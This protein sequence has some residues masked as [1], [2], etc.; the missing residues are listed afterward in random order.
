M[1]A[2]LTKALQI[3]ALDNGMS[4]KPLH[5]WEWPDNA[6]DLE[7]IAQVLT[8]GELETLVAGEEIEQRAI[9]VENNADALHGFLNNAFDGPLTD[10][11]FEET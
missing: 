9:V 11:F 6:N 4:T 1:Y 8:D 2:R 7:A 3:M 10:N 5:D